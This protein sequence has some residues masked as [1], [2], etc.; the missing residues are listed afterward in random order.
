M[1]EQALALHRQGR[2]AEAEQAYRAILAQDPANADVGH[3]LGTLA[4]DA[5]LPQAA[6]PIR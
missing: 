3:L 1:L 5:G 2:L 4:L 6:V